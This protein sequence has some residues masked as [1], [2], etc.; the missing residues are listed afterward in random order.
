MNLTP[1]DTE[2]LLYLKLNCYK[3]HNR[4]KCISIYFLLIEVRNVSSW[5]TH[6]FDRIIQIFY[7]GEQVSGIPLDVLSRAES[8]LNEI[9]NIIFSQLQPQLMCKLGKFRLPNIFSLGVFYVYFM[10]NCFLYI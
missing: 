8:H 4:I 9:R 5:K 7:T 3:I 6:V 2:D 1:T 10:N